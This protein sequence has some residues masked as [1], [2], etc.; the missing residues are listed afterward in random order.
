MLV[1]HITYVPPY[2]QVSA[3]YYGNPISTYG[4]LALELS[5]TFPQEFPLFSYTSLPFMRHHTW[6]HIIGSSRKRQPDDISR[7]NSR[8][9]LN[10][11]RYQRHTSLS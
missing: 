4:S 9:R 10:I 11:S 6:R 1:P 2:S 7:A 5:T 3:Q 8:Y